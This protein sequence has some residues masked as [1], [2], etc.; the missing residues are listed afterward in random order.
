[1]R[2]MPT[3]QPSIVLIYKNAGIC[4]YHRHF[5][6]FGPLFGPYGLVLNIEYRMY[7]Y[8]TIKTVPTGLFPFPTAK[9]HPKSRSYVKFLYKLHCDFYCFRTANRQFSFYIKYRCQSLD[10]AFHQYPA[11]ACVCRIHGSNRLYSL[12]N[13]VSDTQH[14]N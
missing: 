13:L 8:F 4:S 5:Y 12:M 10:T 3:E 6:L 2:T 7:R 14:T 9:T 1:M 11:A